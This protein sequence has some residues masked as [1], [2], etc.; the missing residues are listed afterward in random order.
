MVSRDEMK[1]AIKHTLF[2]DYIQALLF[3]NLG[4]PDHKVSLSPLSA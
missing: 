2:F 4:Q 1:S 3:T